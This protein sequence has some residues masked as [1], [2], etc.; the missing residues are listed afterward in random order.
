MTS[1]NTRRTS[2]PLALALIAFTVAAVAGCGAA[3]PIHY[4][5]V[6]SMTAAPPPPP[7]LSSAATIVIGRIT[8]PYVLRDD[9]ILYKTG[10][11]EMGLYD[12]R[13]WAAPP[14]EMIQS[15]L[16]E[17]LRS[18]GQFRNVQLRT[19]SAVGSFLLR[20]NLRA[21]NEVDTA[22]GITARFGLRLELY[23]AKSGNL[24][25]TQSFLQDEPVTEKTVNA[26]VVSLQKAVD[27]VLSQV[28]ASLVAYFQQHPGAV[29]KPAATVPDQPGTPTSQ[30][31]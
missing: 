3:R 4:Y 23:E 28:S 17:R 18:T 11:V 5:S 13:R 21:F 20:G 1:N 15:M 8:A 19:T 29:D 10:E 26:V 12:D 7:N 9:R 31:Q 27:T 6:D 16:V 2:R 30:P 14:T 24:V 22:S 25:W